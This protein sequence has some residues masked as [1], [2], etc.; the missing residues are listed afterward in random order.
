MAYLAEE[1]LARGVAVLAVDCRAHGESD[2]GIIG[3]GYPDSRDLVLWVDLVRTRFGEDTRIVLHGVSM[4]AAAVML[5]TASKDTRARPEKIT[6]V[7]A[8]C[9][10]SSSNRQFLNMVELLF[11]ASGVQKFVSAILIAGM[12]VINFV[13]TG[14]FSFQNAPTRALKKRRTSKAGDVPLVLFH[15][16]EDLLVRA[17]M[18]D[19]LVNAAGGKNVIVEKIEGAPHKGCYFYEPERYM[20]AVFSV[21]G[22]A[23]L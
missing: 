23:G 21:L 12:S 17:D 4:G 14:Y 1:Y 3:M 19:L 22:S 11:G 16:S 8:D 6:A 18:L 10:Y 2:G 9:G 7:I 20:N 5:F 13:M 15:G